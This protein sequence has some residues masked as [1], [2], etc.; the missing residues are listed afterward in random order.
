MDRIS[1]QDVGDHKIVVAT[2]GT[3]S[4]CGRGEC[5]FTVNAFDRIDIV[6]LL[7]RAEQ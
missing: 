6:Q 3:G 5:R 4:Y 1:L 2:L 7:G